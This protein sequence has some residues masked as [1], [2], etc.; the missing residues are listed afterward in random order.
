MQVAKLYTLLYIIYIIHAGEKPDPINSPKR[1]L[2]QAPSRYDSTTRDTREVETP[3][4][5]A[6]ERI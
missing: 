4:L 2:V 3:T 6:Y 5:L 1:I